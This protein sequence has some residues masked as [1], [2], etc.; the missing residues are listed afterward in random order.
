MVWACSVR[1]PVIVYVLFICLLLCIKPTG[2][3]LS[4]CLL[5]CIKQTGYVLSVCLLLCIKQTGYVLSVCLLLCIKQTGY[6]FCPVCQ[7]LCLSPSSTSAYPGNAIL[8]LMSFQHYCCFDSH[9]LAFPSSTTLQPYQPGLRGPAAKLDWAILPG[10]VPVTY[11]RLCFVNIGNRSYECT[12]I[13]S[14]AITSFLAPETWTKA[15]FSHPVG[16]P[17][18]A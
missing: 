6:V 15:C 7:L 13:L 17:L 18:T 9:T 8:W 3:V 4:V 1:L 2:Y 14:L 12:G 5:L 10:S 11:T 16:C